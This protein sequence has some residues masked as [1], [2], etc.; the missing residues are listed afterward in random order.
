MVHQWKLTKN[1]GLNLIHK[2]IRESLME[3]NHILDVN[4]LVQ[5]INE[6]TQMYQIHHL[7][8]YN[9][10]SKYIKS[11]YGG[12]IKF[13][14]NY[15]IYGISYQKNRTMIHLLNEEDFMIIPTNIIKDDEWIIL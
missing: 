12:M 1:E 9:K 13:I 2:T 6:K 15:S 10:L 8:K 5:R 4:E 11:E 14:D 3:S 7:K